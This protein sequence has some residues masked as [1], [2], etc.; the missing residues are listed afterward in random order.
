MRRPKMSVSKY[1]EHFQRDKAKQIALLSMDRGDLRRDPEIPNAV[2]KTWQISFDQIKRQNVLAAVILSRMSFFD[3]Q[4]IPRFLMNQD[5][6]DFEF[7]EAVG[8]LIRFSF[9]RSQ[10]DRDSFDLHP[11]VQ[12]STKK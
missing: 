6:D 9:I 3:R 8:I 4:G 11:L 2:V 10:N 12:L 1:L 5:D 7:D